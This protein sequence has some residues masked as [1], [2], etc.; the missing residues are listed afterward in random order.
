[1]S[2]GEDMGSRGM[3]LCPTPLPNVPNREAGSKFWRGMRR[4]CNH[5]Y[6][7]G[8]MKVVCATEA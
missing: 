4:A 5:S 7:P 6:H 3:G 1:M 8:V 2:G